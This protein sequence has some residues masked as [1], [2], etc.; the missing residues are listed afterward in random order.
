LPVVLTKFLR[1]VALRLDEFGN[2]WNS[3]Q[4]TEAVIAAK[5]AIDFKKFPGYLA[6]GFGLALVTATERTVGASGQVLGE[7][8]LFRASEAESTVKL[9]VR[10]GSNIQT[11]RN[12][13][14]IVASYFV[15]RA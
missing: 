7:E 3:R 9:E 4:A 1:P 14:N 15:T 11:S 6:H 5:P 8:V 13:A 2:L 12:I 10:S